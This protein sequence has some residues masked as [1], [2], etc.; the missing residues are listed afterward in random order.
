MK[1]NQEIKRLE[2]QS[3]LKSIKKYLNLN[4]LAWQQEMSKCSFIIKIIQV[5]K[6]TS[7]SY[8]QSTN[9]F[10]HNSHVFS[11]FTK[12]QWV[13]DFKKTGHRVQIQN[14]PNFLLLVYICKFEK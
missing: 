13:L 7:P 8:T 10:L 4:C 14:I 3:L 2:Q 11:R 12:K 6:K 1:S 5:N 9:V